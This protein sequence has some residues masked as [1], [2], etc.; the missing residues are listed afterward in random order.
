[1]AAAA[2]IGLWLALE[3][4]APPALRPPEAFSL[5]ELRVLDWHAQLRGPLP[6]PGGITIVAIDEQSL[7]RIGHWP[8]PRTRT[9]EIVARLVERGARV[10]ALDILMNEPDQNS[11]L[12]L[13]R[14]L[15]ERYHALHLDRE[16]GPAR[17][18]GKLI[19]GALAAADTDTQMTEVLAAARRV[20]M[21]YF[22]VFSDEPGSA[23]PLDDEGRRLLN[24]SRVVAFATPEAEHA[25]A[26]RRANGVA[27]PL[28]RF[29]AVVAGSGH[30]NVLPDGDG[31]FRRMEMVIQLDQGYY[32]SMSLEAARLALAIPRTRLQMTADRHILL[33]PQRVPTDGRGLLLLSYY[34]PERTFP[35][36]SAADVLEGKPFDVDGHVVLVGFTAHGL[37]DVRSTPFDPVMPGVESQATALANILEGRGLAA[38]T[39]LL[40]AEIGLV[41]LL[42]V[43]A[44]LGPP[45]LGPVWAT[46]VAVV[47]AVLILAVAHIG[48][49]AGFWVL[50]LPPVFALALG[51]LGSVTYQVLVEQR[52]QRWIRRAFMQY[53][54]PALV[55]QLGRDPA[56]LQFGGE[57]RELTVLF[58]DIRG[59]TTFSERH[60]PEEVVEALQEYLTAMVEV[61]F[62]HRGTLDK[63]MGDAIMA[64]FGAPFDNPDHAFQACQAAVEMSALLDEL[65]EKWRAAGRDTLQS[66][67]GI[68]TGEMLV[69]NFGS[70]QRFTYTVIGDQVN[71]AA[72]LESLNKEYPTR[73]HVIISEGTYRAVQERVT[74]RSLGSVTVKGKFQAVEIYDLMDVKRSPAEGAS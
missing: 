23:P 47:V 53:V 73:R 39:W 18:F 51:H 27:L 59:F 44:P 63:F 14:T 46:V 66:G 71:L 50:T 40:L 16:Q 37:M 13:A 65:N 28:S 1:M 9:A 42:A 69:G 34:G 43:L 21:P 4:F 54:P 48:F 17:E 36:L 3:P 30:A 19:E 58:S 57:K 55:Q 38:P 74:A 2:L 35:T 10:V 60:T 52:E 61:V 31:A 56:S 41:L 26:P 7:A 15:A 70:K 72:R 68:T 62:R 11:Q 20:V 45:R 32:P 67:F 24:R 6:T 64:F 12:A 25:V 29:Q 33:G 5:T 22:F 49:R 8:W